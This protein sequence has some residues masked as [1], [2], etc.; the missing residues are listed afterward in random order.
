[1]IK[2]VSDLLENSAIKFSKKI[3]VVD[4]DTSITYSDLYN[5]SLKIASEILRLNLKKKPVLI[6]LPKG[7]D[8]ICAFFGVAISGNFY[9]IVDENTPEE[10]LKSICSILKPGL[11]ISNRKLDDFEINLLSTECFDSYLLDKIL[12]EQAKKTQIDT[13]LCYTLFTSGSTGVPKGVSIMHKS[14]IDYVSWVCE[15]FN[16]TSDEKLVNQAPFYFDNSVL[17][18]Y[19]SIMAGAE[20]HIIKNTEFIFANRVLAYLQK[21]QISMI[22]WVRSV[23]V[24]FANLRV[25]LDLPN[26]KKVLFCGEI[27]PNKQLNFWRKALPD[28][29]FANLYGPTE[30][31]DV[32]SYYI[33]NRDFKDEEILPIGQACK[34][35]ELL[36]FDENLKLVTDPFVKGELYVRGTGLRVGYYANLEKTNEAFIQ[37][38]LQNNYR[39]FIYKTGDIVA[40]NENMELL[41]Y[42]RIDSQIK[43]AGHR[44][45]LGE[46]ESLTNSINGV[47]NAICLFKNEIISLFYEG[48][49][50]QNIVEFLK[51][52]LPH[53]MMPKKI[54]EV[55]KFSLNQNGKIDRKALYEKI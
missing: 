11:I 22:F 46:I 30:I 32:C 16:V 31:T 18:I 34:N 51:S 26:L 49:A 10:R 17:D 7:V 15:T 27:M 13:D 5:T 48:K 38:P 2:N 55:E 42:G 20:L 52:R 4:C 47:K 19:A 12:I 43:I 50:E 40:Y 44:V 54:I 53:Y 9:S 8:A 6:V 35:T 33:C 24:Y 45:E 41:C 29:L 21:H 23:L 25:K 37:N 14:V 28:T 36:V 3:A 1:M 39:E